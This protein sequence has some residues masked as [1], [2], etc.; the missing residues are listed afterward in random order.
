M[1]LGQSVA[2]RLF[3]QADEARTA[4]LG[5]VLRL[6]RKALAP[7]I[8]RAR[9][10]LPINAQ[11]ALQW[12]PQGSIGTLRE[13]LVEGSL[14]ELLEEEDLEV[15]K[16]ATFEALCER[17]ASKLFGAAM[18]RLQRVEPIFA[19]YAELR[20]WLLTPT[21]GLARAS[22]ADLHNQIQA[23]LAPGFLQNVALRRLTHYPRYLKAMRLRTERLRQDPAR[24]QQR[25][26]QVQPYWQALRE[27][28]QA[29][30]RG[31]ALER[32]RWLLEEWRVSVFAQELGTAE[33]V[34][35]KRL[36]QALAQLSQEAPKT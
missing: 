7:T 28:Q 23:L 24:D 27:Y 25:L 34:S 13:E 14:Q 18:T 36:K 10:Q 16:P 19:Q 11:L 12:A 4:H 15:R 35:G 20:G 29:G 2:L 3:E 31:E 6:L 33:R 22:Y 26:L 17:L 8:K 32:F 9:R 21:A 5:G 1:D 30:T